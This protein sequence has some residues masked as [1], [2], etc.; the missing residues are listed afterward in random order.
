MKMNRKRESGEL[1]GHAPCTAC[2]SKDNAA[3]YRTAK[4]EYNSYCFGCEDHKDYGEECPELAKAT[5]PGGTSGV[6][7]DHILRMPCV[8]HPDRYVPERVTALYGVRS[9]ITDGKEVTRYYPYYTDGVLTGFKVRNLPKRFHTIGKTSGNVQLFGQ[10]LFDKGKIVIVTAGEDDAVAAYRMTQWVCAQDKWR[11]EDGKNVKGKPGAPGYAAVSLRHGAKDIQAVK[12]NLAFLEKFDV[13]VFAM[14]QEEGDTLSAQKM[15]KLLTP[16]KGKIASFPLND[17]SDMCKAKR[18]NEFYEALWDA[19]EH[20]PS[21][22]IEGASAIWEEWKKRENYGT[23]PFPKHWGLNW[24]P[25]VYH[26]ALIA[27]TA[28]TGVGKS[29]VLKELQLHL[30]NTTTHGIGVITME[31]PVSMCTGALMG[32]HMGKRIT[33]PDVEVT[34]EEVMLA[35]DALFKSG[36]FIFCENTGIR[37]SEDLIA[38][39]RFMANSR[40]CKVIFLDHLTALVNKFDSSKGGKNDYVEHLVNTLNDLVQELDIA[41]VLVSHVRKTSQGEKKT[42]E[43]GAVPTE[44]SMFGSSAIKQYSHLTLAISRDK[45]DEESPTYL[46]ILKDRLVGRTGKSAPLMFNFETGRYEIHDVEVKD[47]EAY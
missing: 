28:G 24:A 30:Y 34:E 45:S 16:G 33:T 12:D 10:Q 29:T 1:Q 37:S 8:K 2:G 26:P 27:V 36:R 11:K 25:G 22:I 20:R 13:V 19:V 4:G 39:I 14:D 42:Y 9:K 38:K 32:M 5:T 40:D 6:L 41:L 7:L 44:D 3:V 23:I 43:T 46:H 31:E 17:A 15:V 47:E 21:G 35:H 18:F